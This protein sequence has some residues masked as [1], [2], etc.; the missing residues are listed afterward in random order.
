MKIFIWF[1]FVFFIII[2]SLL[3]FVW[4]YSQNVCWM[5]T[6]VCWSK[7]CNEIISTFDS[8]DKLILNWWKLLYNWKCNFNVNLDLEKKIKLWQNFTDFTVKITE[9]NQFRKTLILERLKNLIE[10][11]INKKN[12]EFQRTF[13]DNDI[14]TILKLNYLNILIEQYQ[15]KQISN[16]QICDS[17]ENLICWQPPM[18]KCEDWNFCIQVMPNP[19]TYS[20]QCFMNQ[21]NA[22]FLYSWQCLDR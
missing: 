12:I 2:F 8:F 6:Y 5:K 17:E 1:I 20:N 14:K 21:D 3:N 19:K 22:S 4:V 16:S 11:E 9:Y 13:A 15:K 7:S 10:N 18:P